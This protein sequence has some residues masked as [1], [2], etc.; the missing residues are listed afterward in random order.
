[1]LST[2]VKQPIPDLGI[3][4]ALRPGLAM[5]AKTL[6]DELGPRGIR[7]NGLLPGRVET[8]RVRE[9]DAASDDPVSTRRRHVASIPLRRYGRPEE[10]A[11]A[12]VFLLSPAAAYITGVMLPV[13]GGITR[14][15]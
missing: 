6:A 3:S 15:L 1:V 5:A 7:V 8:E 2:S 11:A 13:D 9:L 12:A 10:F 14:G 4:N